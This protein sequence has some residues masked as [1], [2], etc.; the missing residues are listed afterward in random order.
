MVLRVGDLARALSV[1]Q[2]ATRTLV[3]RIKAAGFIRRELDAD[4]RRASHC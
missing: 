4:D 2:G 3:D 1:T